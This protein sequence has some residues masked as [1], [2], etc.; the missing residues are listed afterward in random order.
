M[1]K[2]IFTVTNDLSFDQRMQRICGSLAANGYSVTLVG[3]KL[4]ASPPL[5]S[6]SFRQ[7]RLPCFFKKGML[8]Y[9]EFNIRLFF[10]LLF[11]PAHLVCAIDLDT[12][13]PCLFVSKIKRIARVYDAHELFTEMKELLTRPRVRRVWQWI[14]G[15]AVPKFEKGYTVSQSI[16]EEFNRRYGVQYALIR[17]LPLP[18]PAQDEPE[19]KKQFILYQGAVNE[20][21]G[22][23]GLIPAMKAVDA[24][25]VICGSGNLM[26]RCRQLVTE[27]GLEHK[28]EFRGMLKPEALPAITRQAR[29]GINL[30]EPF[31]LNQQFSLANKFFDYIAA[32]VPQVTMNFPEYKR[33][34]GKWEVAELVDDV[35]PETIARALNNLLSNLVQY[36]R[37]Q[38]NCREAAIHLNWQVEEKA[39]IT[40]YQNMFSRIA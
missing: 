39:L 2:I 9:A 23:E 11:T 19:E 28:I 32:G 20:A 27:N 21:R 33:I 36:N 35:K 25:L 3:R 30:V 1:K 40:F 7:K 13:L 14:E 4:P 16:V 24:Q 17:N 10:Y 22:L 5:S 37:L 31:G 15:F 12:I 38:A 18:A 6:F 8:F 34:N 26:D 29:I